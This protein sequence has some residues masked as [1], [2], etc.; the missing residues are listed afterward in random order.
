MHAKQ[1][2]GCGC[3]QEH[4]EIASASPLLEQLAQVSQA[5][6]E[7]V[8][9]GW[10]CALQSSDTTL[11]QHRHSGSPPRRAGKGPSAQDPRC[12]AD[13]TMDKGWL[14]SL[15]RADGKG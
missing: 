13:G 6:F 11:S 9:A 5:L 1:A 7:R 15:D 4:P 3:A 12:G 14:V 10:A 2:C 8:A